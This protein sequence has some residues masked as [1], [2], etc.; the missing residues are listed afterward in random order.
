VLL[1]SQPEPPRATQSHPEP[2][3]ASQS[4]PEPARGSQ[5]RPEP[6]RASQSHSEPHKASQTR[7]ARRTTVLLLLYRA[8]PRA[9]RRFFYCYTA[10]ALLNRTLKAPRAT[11]SHPELARASHIRELQE[12]PA[13]HSNCTYV[14]IPTRF[15]RTNA[16]GRVVIAISGIRYQMHTIIRYVSN[17]AS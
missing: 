8:R 7:R 1:Q 16:L 12:R 2:A 6:A 4:Q 17:L 11:Q 15:A 5:T 9:E 3:R 14:Q 10:R 13:M